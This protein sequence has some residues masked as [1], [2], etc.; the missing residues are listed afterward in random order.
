MTRQM[1]LNLFI[2]SRGHHEA[3][4]RHPESTPLSVFDIRYYQDVARKAEAGCFDSIFLADQLALPDDISQGPRTGLEPITVLA[5][6]AVSTARIGLIA[7]AS[8]TYTQPFN[9]ARQFASIDHISNGRVGWNIVTS[10]LATAASNFDGD[11]QLSHAE[12]YARGE[13]YMAVVKGLWDSWA[14]DA[15]VDDRASGQYAK[16]DRIRPVKHEGPYYSVAGP[17]NLPRSPQGRPVL[18]QAGS[19]ETGRAF[20]ARHAEAIFTA[21]IEQAD[22]EAFYADIKSRAKAEGRDPDQVLILPG[23]SPLVASS[24][25]EAER[26]MRELGE[27]TDPEVGRKRLSGRFGGYDF[28]HL[29]LDKPLSPEDFPDPDSVEA[30]R[31]RTEMVI[32]MVRK[33]KLTLR[34]VL[35][36]LAG[37]RGHYTFAGTPER[38]ADIMEQWFRGRAADGFNVMPPLL[39]A[40]LETFVD[41]V[42]PILR[43]RGL[44]RTG[45]EG[46]TLRAHYGLDEPASQ[47]D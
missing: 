45:Y 33:D 19:S 12:R 32:N 35:A 9:L 28:S 46:R 30:A 15:L 38:V 2:H 25:A 43:R 7:T 41:E 27:L 10:W 23:L 18:V 20:A 44:F 31:S 16:A 5:A 34:Q 40:G 37:A 47:F 21:Q 22:A 13:E 14:A 39:P 6:L 42:L 8:T 1:H 3:S 4:W 36:H 29:P 26:M 24:D 11:G 17:L